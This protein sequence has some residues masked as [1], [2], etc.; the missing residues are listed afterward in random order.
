MSFSSLALPETQTGTGTVTETGQIETVT[1][2]AAATVLVKRAV[3]EAAAAGGAVRTTCLLGMVG[4][5]LF[6]TVLF[7]YS[8]EAVV[9]PQHAEDCVNSCSICESNIVVVSC[10]CH[11]HY[12]PAC[13]SVQGAQPSS[14]WRP[15]AQLGL[16]LAPWALAQDLGGL[17][18]V[19][20]EG[21]WGH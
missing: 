18:G 6:V 9:C 20:L 15:P 7:D 5:L 1:G 13:L 10:C 11:P 21:Q 4:C 3:A 19:Q 14:P 12:P 16:G 2:I 8:S 17:C